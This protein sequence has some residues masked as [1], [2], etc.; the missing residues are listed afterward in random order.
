MSK[1]MTDEEQLD[2][3]QNW[4]KENGRTLMMIVVLAVGAYLGWQWWNQY[5][6][7]YAEEASAIYV[8]LT[9]LLDLPESESL[10]D[11]KRTQVQA[12]IAQLQNDY[13]RTLYAANASLFAAKLATDDDDM[14]SAEAALKK[15]LA[16]GGAD[17]AVLANLR[18]AR[19]YL[20]QGK[21]DDALASANYEKTDDF[22]GL[23]AAVRGDI[24]AAKGDIDAA[25]T[26]YQLAL[27]N[28]STDNNLQRRLVSIKL[29]D[30]GSGDKP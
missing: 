25:R 20:A 13:N 4:W 3:L 30:L 1:Y 10:S 29:S 22:T 17:I 26:A 21:L 11:E 5:Q 12:L 23:Y 15:A 8:T 14:T 19:L 7:N 18:L 28:L 9:D 2:V 24:F 16:Q 6:K 27:D